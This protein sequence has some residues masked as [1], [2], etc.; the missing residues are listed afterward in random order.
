MQTMENKKDIKS[1]VELY[2]KHIGPLTDNY[3]FDF[4]LR[5][6]KSNEP[7]C[8]FLKS[9]KLL[10]NGNY[11][12]KLSFFY[13]AENF[14]FAEFSVF[15]EYKYN[16][17]KRLLALEEKT[18]SRV[19]CDD[20]AN[21]IDAACEENIIAVLDKHYPKRIE[22]PNYTWISET[23]PIPTVE[24]ERGEGNAEVHEKIGSEKFYGDLDAVNA[25]YHIVQDDD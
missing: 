25:K 20:C 24:L 4:P 19:T 11:E 10:P 12:A 7:L 2:E 1:E 21:R 8:S 3:P 9:I 18:R 5:F 22:I 14:A 17:Q 23:I 13:D 16:S 15:G 6:I